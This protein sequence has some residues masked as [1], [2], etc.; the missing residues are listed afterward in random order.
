MEQFFENLTNPVNIAIVVA[1]LAVVRSIGEG[2]IRI[3]EQIEGKDK[4]DTIGAKLM[5]VVKFVGK[6]LTYFGLGNSK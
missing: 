2:L 5:K 3:G 6:I 4:F 1:I